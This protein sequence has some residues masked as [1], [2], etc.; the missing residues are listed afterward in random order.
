M[1]AR[2]FTRRDN[3]K[4]WKL[5]ELY[6][7][8]EEPDDEL[9]CSKIY[10]TNIDSNTFARLKNRLASDVNKAL[11]MTALSEKAF[12]PWLL[13]LIFKY[14]DLRNRH[15]VAIYYLRKALKKAEETGHY[16]LGL[17]LC[18]N[19]LR[20]VRYR[21]MEK[22]ETIRQ[23]RDNLERLSTLQRRL[24]T[25]SALLEEELRR[26]QSLY[27]PQA[28]LL[29]EAEKVASQAE[30]CQPLPIPLLLL[31]LKLKAQIW[32][33]QHRFS[34]LIE[35]LEPYIENLLSSDAPTSDQA[36]IQAILLI[37]LMNAYTI[38]G[39]YEKIT[40]T[41]PLLEKL[42]NQNSELWARYGFFYY[43]NTVAALC[44]TEKFA[45]ALSVIRRME[46]ETET[47]VNPRYLVFAAINK[48]LCLYE[49]GQWHDALKTLARL[50]TW[51]A[52]EHTDQRLQI[53]AEILEILLRLLTHDLEYAFQRVKALLKDKTLP[54][55]ADEALLKHL[56]TL[57]RKSIDQIRTYL[58]EHVLQDEILSVH[59]DRQVIRYRKW[60]QVWADKLA[61]TKL[62]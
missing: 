7:S 53:Q 20:S 16:E 58:L 62:K 10:G 5:L 30:S 18:H 35:L 50:K 15:D 3:R 34:N 56:N 52:F 11:I 33:L 48:A 26:S 55:A 17:M 38:Q 9:I 29:A 31:W 12:E 23:K 57:S 2:R 8:A 4:D 61:G 46:Q 22:E 37:Y 1:Y 59:E 45:E 19:F 24:E 32:I 47:H 39:S 14:H 36:E 49:T 28:S 41:A 27:E 51:E 40:S 54:D 43:Q 6:R 44:R 42:L 13:F 25:Q 21:A 60:A